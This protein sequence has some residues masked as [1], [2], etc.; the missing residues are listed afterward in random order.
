M[1][2]NDLRPPVGSKH[3]RK[4]I[5]RGDGSGHGTT[6]TRGTKGQKSRSGGNIHPRFR[7]VSSRSN[8]MP[9]KRGF[10]NIFRLEYAIVNLSRLN[11]FEPEAEVSPERLLEAGLVKSLRKP[12][13][14]LGNGEVDR[15]LVVRADKFSQSA[16]GK[17]EAVGGR[18]EEIVSDSNAKTS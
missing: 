18:V 3:K 12:I 6:A 11:M 2:Q 17:I 13:K 15:P 4:R 9:T 14:V 10:T 16:K 5:G 1:K 7:G 8:R